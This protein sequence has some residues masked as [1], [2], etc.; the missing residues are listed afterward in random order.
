MDVLIYVTVLN[1]ADEWVATIKMKGYSHTIF[2]AIVLKLVMEL[3]Q[4]AEHKI[5][6][7]FC[8]RLERKIVG[9]FVMWLVVFSSKFLFLALDDYVFGD[10]VELGDIWVRND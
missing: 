1:L 4:Y 9:A 3:I 5:Q 7:F 8:V 10:D 2:V 6:H